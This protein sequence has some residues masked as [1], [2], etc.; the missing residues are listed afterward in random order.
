MLFRNDKKD[1]KEPMSGRSAS[2][3]APIAEILSFSR[4]WWCRLFVGRQRSIKALEEATQKQSPI[5][6]ILAKRRENERADRR[7]YL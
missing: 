7:R 1:E 2:A 5:F 3:F 4:I 6:L